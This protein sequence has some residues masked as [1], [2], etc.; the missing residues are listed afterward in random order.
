MNSSL[1]AVSVIAL[2]LPAAFMFA[3]DKSNSQSNT[4]TTDLSPTTE[5]NDILM[6]SRGVSTLFSRLRSCGFSL[7]VLTLLMC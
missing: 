7:G 6:M 1:L 2:L 5:G 3:V 4:D